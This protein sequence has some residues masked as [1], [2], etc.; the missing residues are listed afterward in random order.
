MYGSSPTATNIWQ[1]ETR[2]NSDSSLWNNRMEYSTY[3]LLSGKYVVST[4][5]LGDLSLPATYKV[6][7]I[8][9]AGYFDKTC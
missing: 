8:L 2:Q 9:N 5:V 6:I 1:S 4:N 7:Q 3:F